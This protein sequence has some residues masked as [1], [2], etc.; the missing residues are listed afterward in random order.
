MSQ[1][2]SLDGL[3]DTDWPTPE[4]FEYSEAVADI[5]CPRCDNRFFTEEGL[6][7]HQLDHTARQSHKWTK[8]RK[9]RR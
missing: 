5:P 1:W 4:P 8:Q 9:R 7:L 6:A 2:R 3:I